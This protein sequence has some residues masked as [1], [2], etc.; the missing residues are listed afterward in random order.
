MGIFASIKSFV[1]HILLI[2]EKKRSKEM[3][4]EREQMYCSVLEAANE[5]ERK[6][7]MLFHEMHNGLALHEVICNDSG[8]P[9]DYRY[10]DVNPAFER[11][12]GLQKEKVIGRTVLEVFPNMEPYWLEF[13]GRVALSGEPASLENFSQEI[14]RYFQ[15]T[16]FKPA[17]NQIACILMDVTE[18]KKT[19]E[20]L[21]KSEASLRMAQEIANVGNWS[22]EFNTEK[23]YWSDQ[24]YRILGYE[25]G[26]VE[27]SVAFA[28]QH[29]HP[30]DLAREIADSKMAYEK[31]GRIYENESRLVRRDGT[32]R[33]IIARGM[34]F[35][36]DQDG[37]PLHVIGTTQD[38]TE[39]K[40]AELALQKS[41]EQHRFILKTAMDGYWMVDSTGRF[42]EVNQT[43]CRMSGYSEQELLSMN[44]ADVEAIETAD[45]V[46]SHMKTLA[47]KGQDRFESRHR[48]KDGTIYDIEASVQYRADDGGWYICFI[49]DIT[50]KKRIEAKLAQALKM[51]SIGN[52]A[53]GI[54]HDFNNI[55]FP[56]VGLAEMLIYDLPA[57]SPHRQYAKDIFKAGM[58][59]GSL[60]KQILAFSRQSENKKVPVRF[61]NI[62]Q[63]V[64]KLIRSTIPT[65]IDINQD[66]QKECGMIM[67][68]PT[69][70][71][72]I[73][74]NLVTNA[75]HAMEGKDGRIDV[76]LKEVLLK[77]DAA[78]EISLKAGRYARLTVTDTGCGI[79]AKLMDKIFDPYFTTKEQGKGTGLGL[80]LVFGIVKEHNG[81][82]KV[83]SEPGEGTTFT[84]YLPLIQDA[85]EHTRRDSEEQ[86]PRGNEHIL[87]VDDESA[88][89]TLEQLMLE[90][91]GYQ[92]TACFGSIEALETFKATPDA[93]DLV[94]TD[95]SMPNM[96]GDRLAKAM[97]AIRPDIP[98]II[99]SGF[100]ERINQ[101]MPEAI[102]VRGF[103]MKPIVQS[104]LVR[105]VRKVLDESLTHGGPTEA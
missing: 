98:I 53:G 67:A 104:E 50:E 42:L 72:Q 21:K 85:A 105:A 27:I 90:R 9:I 80:A 74:M 16:S 43:Y 12:T 97:I 18:R 101:D 83:Y 75:Y 68:D 102:G 55:L 23:I 77:G 44:I 32:V 87:I 20:A 57:E 62:L 2:I 26:E 36:R 17:K 86:L 54:A 4:K 63:E 38:I 41:A 65:N 15:V 81:E 99:C 25:P 89:V 13:F 56:I 19:E 33:F 66:I 103:L 22:W 40:I 91:L 51:E 59:G 94:L 29:I 24:L 84:V 37:T 34:V 100:S 1:S 79:P 3:L 39:R 58:R 14:G 96:T 70:L 47:E 11:M 69:Q 45:Q 7:Q 28:R 71:H 49:R 5:A 73:V 78:F 93:F 30:D 35:K 64:L 48:R 10:L 76:Q 46:L 31:P 8:I 92:V 52:L 60:V 88:I 82:I 6:Y 95:M 61:Q